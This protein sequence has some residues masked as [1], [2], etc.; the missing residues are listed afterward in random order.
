MGAP[1]P[2]ETVAAVAANP[3]AL[4]AEKRKKQHWA[5]QPL[6]HVAPPAVKRAGW[7]RTPID[8]FILA[9]L[10]ARNLKP[11]PYADR[12]TLL[13]RASYDLIGLPPTPEEVEAF[14]SDK[15]PSAYEKVVDRLLASPHYGERWGRFWLDIAR[16][17][18][19][20][21]HSFEPR[22]YPQG[23]RYR[24]WVAH[25]LNTDMPY[26]KFVR[27]QIAADLLPDADSKE[28][29]PALGFFATGPVYYGD[30]KMFDQYDDR[31]DTLSRGFLGLTVACARCHDHKFDPI[32]QKDYYGLAGIFAS[33]AYI[34]VPVNT[35]NAAESGK[36]DRGGDRQK[37]IQAKTEEV[38]K[39]TNEQLRNLRQRFTP[40]TARY[41]FSTWKLL[42]RRKTDPKLTTETFAAQEG[43][44]TLVLERWHDYLMA[45]GDH[46]ALAAWRDL[47]KR[48][49]ARTDF[50]ASAPAQ[51]EA[52]KVA[53][54]LQDSLLALQKRRTDKGTMPLTQAENTRLDEI[55]GDQGVLTLPKDRFEKLL[56]GDPKV[57]YAVI[58][59]E[60]ERLKMGAFVH[61][62]TEGPKPANVPI[63]LRGN[64]ET[65]GA[66]A[67]RRFL[68]I[69]AGR[70]R[71][72]SRRAAGG[73]N[74]PTPLQREVT[75]SRPASW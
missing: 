72:P 1:W 23:F 18:E 60:L 45:E 67:P 17:G 37:L 54:E 43:L 24:D 29:L 56:V 31:I 57:H 63:L 14:V 16:Y 48:Q 55:V 53:A 2:R 69:L 3:A 26:D 46:P 49:D 50:S 65:P 15:S 12:R 25:A 39:F 9:G 44:E 40:E 68:T 47:R 28:N 11:N 42:N 4:L 13:R 73:S 62:L 7:A 75:R 30:S 21:A 5:W 58:K 52:R 34:E 61:A 38:D 8:R 20:Q 66:E 51:E 10:E 64:P 19:D 36:A 32:S 27:A 74:S 33:T 70:T 35:P 41:V 71:P 6:K 22:L 59:A